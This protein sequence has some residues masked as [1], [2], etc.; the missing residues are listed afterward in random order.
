MPSSLPI[1]LPS[2]ILTAEDDRIDITT[3]PDPLQ[4]QCTLA[5]YVDQLTINQNL[6]EW[7]FNDERLVTG[8]KYVIAV[9]SSDCPPYGRCGLGFVTIRN[10]NN[11]D[12]GDYVCSF[13]NLSQTITLFSSEISDMPASKYIYSHKL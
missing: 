5:G 2:G 11:D 10:L 1:S 12:L 7:R 3:S 13:E 6:I 4:L 8:S 9:A